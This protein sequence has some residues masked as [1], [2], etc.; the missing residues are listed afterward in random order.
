[1]LFRGALGLLWKDILFQTEHLF[2]YNILFQV[3]PPP[4]PLLHS[5][6]PPEASPS[7]VWVPA[8]QTEWGEQAVNQKERNSRSE[9]D[10]TRVE[11]SLCQTQSRTFSSW[12]ERVSVCVP[13]RLFCLGFGARRTQNDIQEGA[14]SK[15]GFWARCVFLTVK[16][17]DVDSGSAAS[18]TQ[19]CCYYAG[20]L[21]NAWKS[22]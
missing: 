21:W 9:T 22:H 20:R 1:M 3:S 11:A 10:S 15:D 4:S 2:T 17:H 19:D 7:L 13:C 16:T 18:S 8:E 6:S 5:T 12:L 14:F